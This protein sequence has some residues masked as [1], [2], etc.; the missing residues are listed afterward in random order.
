MFFHK[1]GWSFRVM[2]LS[3]ARQDQNKVYSRPNLLCLLSHI[4]SGF[5][6]W[7]PWWMRLSVPAV[8]SS[9]YSQSVGVC[10]S[11]VV[12]ASP[13]GNSCSGLRQFSY[14]L[15]LIDSQL[16]TWGGLPVDF[17][18][19]LPV[20]VQLWPLWY[21]AL[22]SPGLPGPVAPSPQLEREDKGLCHCLLPAVSWPRVSL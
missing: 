12:H 5:S 9:R 22:Q 16:K 17:Q 1:A 21:F 18:S 2:L 13:F 4:S 20:C 11:G 15:M 3:F 19:S 7:C 6:T 10:A 8:E 14:T